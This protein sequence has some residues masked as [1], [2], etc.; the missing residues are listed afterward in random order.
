MTTHQSWI[1]LKLAGLR[2]VFPII[3]FK[4]TWDFIEQ[5]ILNKALTKNMLLDKDKTS[6]VDL[7]IIFVSKTYLTFVFVFMQL[8]CLRKIETFLTLYMFLRPSSVHCTG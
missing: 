8:S 4:K 2:G 5:Q 1:V 7:G 6:Y 3:K